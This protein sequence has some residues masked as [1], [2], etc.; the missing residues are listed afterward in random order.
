ML[1]AKIFLLFLL[2]FAKYPRALF[3]L[4]VQNT[5]QHQ[6]YDVYVVHTFIQIISEFVHGLVGSLAAAAFHAICFMYE[7]FILVEAVYFYRLS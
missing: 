3:H 7:F 4:H 2:Q 5:T 6:L 1:F